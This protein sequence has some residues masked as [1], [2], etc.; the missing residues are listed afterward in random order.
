MQGKGRKR[1]TMPLLPEVGEAIAA[2]LRDGRPISGSRRVFL[3]SHAP[4]IGFTSSYAV[5][6]IARSA[7]NAANITGVAHRG[8]H[9]FRHSLATGLLGSGATLTEIG[10]VLRHQNHD[11]TRIYAKVDL[12]SLRRLATPWPGAVQ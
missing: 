9:L 3:R 5:I 8:S 6:H 4:H 10:Q 7:I 2:Y 12:A 11:T 1:A